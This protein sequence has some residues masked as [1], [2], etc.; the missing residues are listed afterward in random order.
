MAYKSLL[1]VATSPTGLTAPIAAACQI[2][3]MADAH[4]D[5]LALGVDHTQVGYAYVGSGA[6]IIATAMDRAEEDARATEKAVNAALAQQSPGVRTA[7]E[8][9]V[10]QLGTLTDIVA[11]RAR[12]A[13]LVVLQQPY[14]KGRGVDDEAVIEAALF[15]GMAPVLV[16]PDKGMAS[17]EPRRIVVAW[18]QS[19]EA[20]VAARAALPFLKRADQVSIVVIDPPTHG[21]E[22]SDPGGLI[23]QM[24]VRHG[25]RAEV[26][27]LARTLPRVSDVLA[28]HLRDANADLLVMGAYGHSRLREAI[29]GGATRDMLENAEVPVFLAH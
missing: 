12:Y 5:L 2:A 14:G 19:R 17:A 23:C 20:L 10:C 8:T 26:T 15:A 6:V 1:T 9:A 29:L 27:V 25:V 16:V 3:L 28:R 4:L 22:R 24:L 7:V 21:P 18:N 11:T 13:D